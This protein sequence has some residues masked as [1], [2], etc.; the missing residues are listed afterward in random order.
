MAE[1]KRGRGRPAKGPYKGMSARISTRLT[2]GLRTRLE[3]SATEAGRSL[4]QEINFRLEK[5]LDNEDQVVN[6][7]E[8]Y[9][10]T[11]R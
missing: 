2:Q 1:E 4:S 8:R 3:Q 7:L 11:R 10:V 6:L 5:S 9:N